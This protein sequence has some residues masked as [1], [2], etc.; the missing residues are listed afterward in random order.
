MK[1]LDALGLRRED[2]RLP[3]FS[4]VWSYVYLLTPEAERFL[5]QLKQD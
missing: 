5:S 2:G 3:Q 4:L 1:G